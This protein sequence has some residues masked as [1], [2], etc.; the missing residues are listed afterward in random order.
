MPEIS[1][2]YPTAAL[3]KILFVK[4]PVSADELWE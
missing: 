3:G 4:K 2:F 1:L